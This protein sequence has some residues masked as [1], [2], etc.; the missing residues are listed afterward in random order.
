MNNDIGAEGA[1]SIGEGLKVR[2]IYMARCVF[3]FFA[4]PLLHCLGRYSPLLH[5]ILLPSIT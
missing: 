3:L 1:G 4:L 5:P 2:M